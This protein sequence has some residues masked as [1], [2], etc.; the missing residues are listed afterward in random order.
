MTDVMGPLHH[1]HDGEGGHGE[2][3]HSHAHAGDMGALVLRTP[4]ELAGAEIEISPLDHPEQRR[5]VAVHPRR[6]PGGATIYAAMYYSL[7]AGTY[8]LWAADGT[9]ALTVTV[10]GGIVGECVWP[11]GVPATF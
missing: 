10:Q 11:D 2:H 3:G 8:Q 9:P 1:H 5:H 4:P 6:L 7:R